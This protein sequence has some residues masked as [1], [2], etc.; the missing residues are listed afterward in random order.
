MELWLKR[1]T[2]GRGSLLVPQFPN[3]FL[4]IFV[5]FAQLPIF[6]ICLH[7]TVITRLW[8]RGSDAYYRPIASAITVVAYNFGNSFVKENYGR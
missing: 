7:A 5:L 3:L 8:H 1:K 6:Q 4:L 2:E